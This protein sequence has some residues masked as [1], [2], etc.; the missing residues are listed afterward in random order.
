MMQIVSGP[1]PSK[2]DWMYSILWQFQTWFLSGCWLVLF[3]F[4]VIGVL[5]VN[6]ITRNVTMFL[7]CFGST[8]G[9]LWSVA[10]RAATWAMRQLPGNADWPNFGGWTSNWSM[11]RLH[12]MAVSVLTWWAAWFHAQCLEKENK[13]GRIRST[14]S[15]RSWNWILPLRSWWGLSSMPQYWQCLHSLIN[16]SQFVIRTIQPAAWFVTKTIVQMP[17][18][19]WM[20]ASLS[21]SFPASCVNTGECCWQVEESSRRGVVHLSHV[22][23]WWLYSEEQSQC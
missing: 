4:F 10:S 3:D 14:T 21:C 23:P 17:I 12:F 16:E 13:T 1:A 8:G 2:T 15:K 20:W 19:S 18:E 7:Q 9:T 6:V 5:H 22:V 11:T